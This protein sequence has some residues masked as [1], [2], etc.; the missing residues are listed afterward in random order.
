EKLNGP[1][2]IRAQVRGTGDGSVDGFLVFDASQHIQRPALLLVGGV[3][4]IAFGSHGDLAPYHGWLLGYS[5]A[6]VSKQVSV[7]NS[8]PRGAGGSIWQSGR[9]PAAD[10]AGHIFAVTSN[11]DTDD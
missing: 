6:D 11:G 5:A 1:A 9:G 3:V 4:Y 7:F 2:E 10:D 8:T